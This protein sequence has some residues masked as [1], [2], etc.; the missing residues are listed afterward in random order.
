MTTGPINMNGIVKLCSLIVTCVL[1]VPVAWAADFKI[2]AHRS[3]PATSLTRNELQAIFL[4]EM[5]RWDDGKPIRIVV[6]EEG[7]VHQSFLQSVL[8]KSPSQFETYWNKRVFTG[9]GSAPKAFAE[10]AE[11]VDYVGSHPGTIGYVAAAQRVGSIKTIS[12]K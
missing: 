3:V 10:M 2:I 11:A 7:P 9:K 4:G 12:M 6:L 5:S 8:A 1:F